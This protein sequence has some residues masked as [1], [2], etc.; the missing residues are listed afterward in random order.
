M[1]E[2]FVVDDGLGQGPQR[3]IGMS[4][5]AP[6]AVLMV[7]VAAPGAHADTG[8]VKAWGWG[9]STGAQQFESCTT[10]CQAGVAGV[11]DAG[12]LWGAMGAAVSANGNV[13]V[14]NLDLN[15]VDVFSRDGS[16]VRTFGGGVGGAGVQTCTTGCSYGFSGGG[17]GDIAAPWGV[18]TDASGHVVV[19]EFGNDRVSVFTESGAFVRTFGWG[20]STGASALEVCT[21]NC[22]AE[23]AGS[24]AGELDHPRGVALD[25]AGNMFVVDALN[26][27]VEEFTLTGAHVRSFGALGAGA[28]EMG[29]PNGSDPIGIGVAPS[30]NV[31]VSDT[32][33]HRVNVYSPTGVFV[34]TFGWGVNT[35]TSALE[36]CTSGCQAG[37]P[38]S[39]AGQL[40]HPAGLAVDAAGRVLV[41]DHFNSRVNEYTESGAFLGSF[42][43]A[44]SDAGQIAGLVGLAVD[45]AGRAF[46]A[47]IYNHRL[48]AFDY[49]YPPIGPTM[50]LDQSTLAFGEEPVT[51]TY[52]VRSLTVTNTSDAQLVLGT[53]ALT[54]PDATDFWGVNDGAISHCNNATVLAPGESCAIWVIF[55]PRTAGPKTAAVSITTSASPT[56]SLVTLTGTGQSFPDPPAAS[57]DLPPLSSDIP[58]ASD[59]APQ[60][61]PVVPAA[62]PTRPRLAKSGVPA[63]TARGAAVRVDPAVALTCPKGTDGCR[64]RLTATAQVAVTAHKGRTKNLVV[65]RASI[66]TREG[67][68]ARI[69]FSLTNQGARTLRKLG[70]LRLS[71]VAVSTAAN[72]ATSRF[73]ATVPV[74]P[75]HRTKA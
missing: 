30:G 73:S 24:G 16:F 44:G 40:D 8:F 17:A 52:G 51:S 54:G 66:T 35:G 53:L 20:V 4:L 60:S 72:G 74:K 69:L 46:L 64:T 23:I 12:D 70:R 57:P 38:G 68:T 25:G 28:G 67:G 75:P 13:L 21:S 9:V 26:D 7:L 61:P 2:I 14:G 43:S 33:N 58:P 5:C 48:A 15:R 27:R 55:T 11:G 22:H 63:A 41:S 10:T 37:I 47:D 36:T 34:R 1:I 31:L 62:S 50:A 39:G 19:A 32:D 56:P 18:A 59:L 3:V 45:G 29:A 71:V 49:R 6:V 65:G 42:A